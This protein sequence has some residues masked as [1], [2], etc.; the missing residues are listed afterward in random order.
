MYIPV[1]NSRIKFL[2]ALDILGVNY[3]VLRWG[4]HVR[5]L[6]EYEDI[7]ILYSEKDLWKIT[8]QLQKTSSPWPVDL[9]PS[10]Q[11]LT[12]SSGGSSFPNALLDRILQNKIRTVDNICVPDDETYFY[13]LAYHLLFHKRSTLEEASQL[14][15]PF[16]HIAKTLS[17]L[18]EKLHGSESAAIGSRVLIESLDAEG[19]LPSIE[20]IS[21]I[22]EGHPK[23][24][25]VFKDFFR[26]NGGRV[27]PHLTVFVVR[28]SFS[29][30]VVVNGITAL[31]F[32]HGFHVIDRIELEK[33][34]TERVSEVSRGGNWS[35][36]PYPRSGGRPKVLLVCFDP[37]PEISPAGHAV[38]ETLNKRYEVKTK[39]RDDI[40]SRFFSPFTQS[41]GIHSPDTAE[42]V[43]E[44]LDALGSESLGSKYLQEVDAIVHRMTPKGF[45]KTMD[46]SKTKER[47]RVM[48][49]ELEGRLVFVKTY[50]P[51][52][53]F[54]ATNEAHFL[55]QFS[56]Y[57]SF[58][59]RLVDKG[60]NWICLEWL[61]LR[62]LDKQQTR[63]LIRGY[64]NQLIEFLTAFTREG[65]FVGDFGPNSL[66]QTTSGELKVLD[67]EFAYKIDRGHQLEKS[68]YF[69]DRQEIFD[70][71]MPSGWLPGLE[72]WDFLWAGTS[73]SKRKIKKVLGKRLAEGGMDVLT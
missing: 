38:L 31:L 73:L 37:F 2:S 32:E 63:K 8:G 13:S 24:G 1:G 21:G 56:G 45:S 17:D 23:L 29:D 15:S 72:K 48:K 35:G 28:E 49:G 50:A 62:E 58:L 30:P 39:V 46:L 27:S 42:E 60:T 20:T 67:F 25:A 59:P 3:V 33:L 69:T 26:E 14:S 66:H 70:L 40:N 34:Q 55:E 43:L 9:Y 51:G 7:D 53:A 71:H 61:E 36:G 12:L 5:S 41:N 47:S 52:F 4:D 65:F 64:E 10:A 11:K 18:T 22:V 68:P 44:L 54:L 19:F 16:H 57:Y 6:P